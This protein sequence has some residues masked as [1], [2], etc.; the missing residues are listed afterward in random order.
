MKTDRKFR[1]GDNQW[2][3]RAEHVKYLRDCAARWR[4]PPES[5]EEQAQRVEAKANQIEKGEG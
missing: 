4:S 1:G 5:C 3:T 2:R